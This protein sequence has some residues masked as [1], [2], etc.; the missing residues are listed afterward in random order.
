MEDMGTIYEKVLTDKLF[1]INK[2]DEH[3][4]TL[5]H[6]AAQMGTSALRNYWFKKEAILIIRTSK[7]RRLVIL[8]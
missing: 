3:G 1:H 6:I 5:M 2:S 4:N 7:A 8:L